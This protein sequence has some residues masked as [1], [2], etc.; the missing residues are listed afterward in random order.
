MELHIERTACLPQRTDG[1]LE[2]CRLVALRG[3]T[4]A[5]AQNTTISEG[6]Y[7]TDDI[8]SKSKPFTGCV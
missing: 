3:E 2:R 7:T 6:T 5:P 4:C 1:R 8:Y